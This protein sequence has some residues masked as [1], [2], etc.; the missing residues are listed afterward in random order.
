MDNTIKFKQVD[1]SSLVDRVEDNLVQLLQERKLKVGDSIPTELEL[2][3]ILGV[4][5]TVVREALLRL[6]LMGLIES[7]KKKG[8]VITS[9]DIFSILNKSMNPHILDQ[10]TL[11]EIFE[12]R[13]VLEIGMADFLFQ[14][15]TPED[16]RVLKEIVDNEPDSAQYHLFNIEHEIIFHGKLYDITGNE[17]LRKFQG[18]L[19]PIFDFVHNSGL[20]KKMGSTNKF[21]SHKGLVDILENGSPELFRNAMRNHLENHFNRLFS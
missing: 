8:A 20:L 12:I 4:S 3:A 16:I 11:K 14:R 13:L 21:V 10:D 15:I 18:M 1:T 7:K 6:R 5:R 19:L 9:P 17:T 2:T